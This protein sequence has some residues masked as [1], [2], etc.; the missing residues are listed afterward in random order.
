MEA[1]YIGLSESS[2]DCPHKPPDDFEDS[3]FRECTARC[4]KEC[5]FSILKLADKAREIDKWDTTAGP[6]ESLFVILNQYM[7]SRYVLEKQA[8]G[9]CG[10]NK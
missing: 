2:V 10:K 7:R 4:P 3:Y 8:T 6:A 1:Q 5:R 9:V